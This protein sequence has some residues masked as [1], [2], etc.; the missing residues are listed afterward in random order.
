VAVRYD[1]HWYYI[2]QTDRDTK[3]TFALLLEVSRLEL[4]S[5]EANAP[6]LTIPLGR[7]GQ[8]RK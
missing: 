5:S 2:D 7:Y 1:D 6:L 3:A 4:Q 8:A